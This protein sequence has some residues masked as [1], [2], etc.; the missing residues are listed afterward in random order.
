[1]TD[2]CTSATSSRPRTYSTEEASCRPTDEQR[3]VQKVASE[4]HA[5]RE[6]EAR[7]NAYYEGGGDEGGRCSRAS[8]DASRWSPMLK[9]DPQL[10]DSRRTAAV[11]KPLESDPYG[12]AIIGA[13][14]GGIV[15]GVGAAAAEALAPS[16]GVQPVAQHIAVN[17]AKNVAKSVVKEAVTST[18]TP[19]PEGLSTGAGATD[20]T[21]SA[22]ASP[23]VGRSGSTGT[24]EVVPEP[25]QSVA[26]HR[27][28]LVIR[29]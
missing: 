1:M 18:M 2:R 27:T 4:Q 22:P 8:S 3:E 19:G 16:A 21:T 5:E 25:S 29:G 9:D 28:P 23:P 17:V 7:R 26:P 10:K 6:A 14:A 12:N 20:A 13:V 15:S 24:S 11:D